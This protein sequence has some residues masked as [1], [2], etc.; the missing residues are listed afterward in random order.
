LVDAEVNAL[1]DA[2]PESSS[3]FNRRAWTFAP[4]IAAKG[5]YYSV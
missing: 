2:L 4:A 5:G 1:V 3:R